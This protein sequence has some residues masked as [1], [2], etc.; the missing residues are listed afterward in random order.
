MG[1]SHS[2][3]QQRPRAEL[4]YD[5][6]SIGNVVAIKALWREGTSLEWIDREGRTPLILACM[7]PELIHVAKTLIELGAHVNAYR[8]GAHAGTPLHHAVKEGLGQ[9][10]K[11]LLSHGANTL[12]RNDDFQ[13]PLDVARVKGCANVVRALEKHVC[14][15]SGWFREFYGPSFL[16]ALAPKLLSGTIW[17]VVIPFGPSD[18][19]RPLKMELIIYRTLQDVRPRS[20][21]ALW[22]VKIEKPDFHQ[23]EPALTI[24]DQFTKTRYKLTSTIEG[25]KQQLQR[26][27]NACLGIPQI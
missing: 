14:Y 18:S 25:D 4:L 15:F 17:V 21:I 20:V 12:V 13:T 27:H 16:E 5:L 19:T 26:L 3:S 8:P 24:V 7:N 1:Q 2:T 10:V 11:L 6:V 23:K 9:S 22:K